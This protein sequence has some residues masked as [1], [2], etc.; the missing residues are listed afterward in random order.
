MPYHPKAHPTETRLAVLAERAAK[1]EPL[2]P[3]DDKPEVPASFSD[4][5]DL[6]DEPEQDE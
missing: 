6:E 1:Q 5:P 2:F 4:T 3:P